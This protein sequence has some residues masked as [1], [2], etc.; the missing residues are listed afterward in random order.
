MAEPTAASESYDNPLEEF[1]ARGGTLQQL[2]GISDEAMEATYSMAHAHYESG[3]Y[4]QAAEA[5]QY[6][7][8]HDHEEPRYFMGL[9]ACQQMLKTYGQAAKTFFYVAG[10]DTSD[11]TPLFAM[12]DIYLAL[13]NYDKALAVL[14]E[15]LKVAGKDKRYSNHILRGTMLKKRIAEVAGGES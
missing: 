1:L 3:N 13:R 11:P 5:F 12:V 2:N 7:C 15:A 14:D 4:E 6:L 10:L 8:Y 9:G